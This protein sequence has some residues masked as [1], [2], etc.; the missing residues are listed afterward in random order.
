M[1]SKM[2]KFKE[3]SYSPELELSILE[4][5]TE[6]LFELLKKLGIQYY[7]P[8]IIYNEIFW[9]LLFLEKVKFLE[10]LILKPLFQTLGDDPK[11]WSRIRTNY[12]YLKFLDVTKSVFIAN[13]K[14][15]FDQYFKSLISF[16]KNIYNFESFGSISKNPL[17]KVNSLLPKNIP[18]TVSLDKYSEYL[19]LFPKLL[20]FKLLEDVDL[21]ENIL[22]F[23]NTINQ[24]YL[25]DMLLF[26]KEIQG[27]NFLSLITKKK[28][29]IIHEKGYKFK[30]LITRLEK[31]IEGD[32][33]EYIEIYEVDFLGIKSVRKYDRVI[34]I[35]VLSTFP[36]PIYCKYKDDIYY[37][38]LARPTL[39]SD[40]G[41][42]DENKEVKKIKKK[43]NDHNDKKQ[44]NIHEEKK[45]Q[46]CFIYDKSE[47]IKLHEL[48]NLFFEYTY[49]PVDFLFIKKLMGD[50]E[51]TIANGRHFS[52]SKSILNFIIEL[53]VLCKSEKGIVLVDLYENEFGDFDEFNINRFGYFSQLLNFYFYKKYLHLYEYEILLDEAVPLNRVI[54]YEIYGGQKTLLSTGTLQL[55]LHNDTSFFEKFFSKKNFYL[56]DEVRLLDKRFKKRYN[57]IKY[58]PLSIG[59]IRII[60]EKGF[61]KFKKQLLLKAKERKVSREHL[62]FISN[63]SIL[64]YSSFENE[65]IFNC[66]KFFDDKITEIHP[67]ITIELEASY[68]NEFNQLLNESGLDKKSI[69]K[70]LGKNKIKLAEIEGGMFKYKLIRFIDRVVDRNSNSKEDKVNEKVKGRIYS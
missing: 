5:R 50:K 39:L 6:Q 40:E 53:R 8:A 10:D 20:S 55:H 2:R 19:D 66:M 44:Q 67:Y 32:V 54:S 4:F 3:I 49:V 12:N 68:D 22:Y 41:E 24:K 23:I 59:I 57:L 11:Y 46:K 43:T 25:L 60:Y 28:F 61:E 34:C 63:L 69:K 31:I 45:S 21:V 56:I 30:D 15:T 18:E 42:K 17:L 29:T 52:F 58:N 9:D 64:K 26:L 38:L 47:K 36:V 16:E 13:S 1:W 33:F 35:E 7:Y 48:D 62:E 65:Y 27:E 37:E 51:S 70:V 14:Y